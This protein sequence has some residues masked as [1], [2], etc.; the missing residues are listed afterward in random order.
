[1]SH[2]LGLSGIAVLGLMAVSTWAQAPIPPHIDKVFGATTIAGGATTSLTFTILTQQA[3][4]SVSFTDTLP[5]GL[6]VATPNGLSTTCGTGT[7]TATAGSGTVS[8]TGMV[9][10]SAGGCTITVNVIGL[11][12]GAQV[13][14]VTVSDA[15][16]G[17]GNTSTA[18]LN[19]EVGPF[20]GKAFGAPQIVLLG[21][22]P[23][24][25]TS[26]TFQVTNSPANPLP[27]TGIAFTD[28]LPSGLVVA[29]PN[30]LA[31]SCGGGTITAAAGGSSISLSGAT[32]APGASCIFSVNV[33]ANGIG[34]QV[35]STSNVTA[36]GG[37]VPLLGLPAQATINVVFGDPT[38]SYQIN[39]L[40]AAGTGI[41]G[42]YIDISNDGSLGADAFGPLAGTTGRIC[43]NVYTFTAD[44]QESECCSCLVTPNAFGAPD[45]CR[46][47][48]QPGQ[49]RNANARTR[50]E[51]AGHDPRTWRQH[52]G[53]L[54]LVGLQCGADLHGCQPGTGHDGLGD[55]V[56]RQCNGFAEYGPLTD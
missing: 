28:T 18:T 44:E 22:T 55:Q 9:F 47:N 31:G 17:V 14:S 52:A 41:A 42:G 20:L 12:A 37:G 27:L 24:D 35:N 46:S 54:H 15:V 34:T 49:R 10:P 4:T 3:L 45:G 25:T 39:Y 8:A 11:L 53:Y 13:N 5:G 56:P 21:V 19:V 6:F 43:V 51:V 7:I 40:P 48:R 32:L 16:A 36:T 30:G 2:R 26:L 29:T 1:M 23:T 33:R 38:S 50:R